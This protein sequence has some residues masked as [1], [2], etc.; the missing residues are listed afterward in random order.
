M[1]ETRTPP[2]STM[3]IVR[4]LPPFPERATTR[5]PRRLDTGTSTVRPH[6]AR[7]RRRRGGGAMA[8]TTVERPADAGVPPPAPHRPL[9]FW[10]AMVVVVTI[11]AGLLFGYDQGVISGALPF[12]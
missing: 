3:R 11:T 4:T 7:Q 1:A 5:G 2:T 9:R 8:D 6:P 10:M 12:I